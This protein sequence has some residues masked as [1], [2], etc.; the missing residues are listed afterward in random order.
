ML[1]TAVPLERIYHNFRE[2]EKEESQ[3]SNEYKDFYT[4]H[5]RIHTKRTDDGYEIDYVNSTDMED[6]LNDTYAIGKRVKQIHS[7]GDDI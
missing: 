2:S 4:A 6:Y 5:G 7:F 3:L 1:Y